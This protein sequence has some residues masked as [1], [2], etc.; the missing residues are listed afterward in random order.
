MSNESLQR[1]LTK[2]AK[3]IESD[4]NL[5]FKTAEQSR[6]KGDARAHDHFVHEGRIYR[7]VHGMLTELMRDHGFK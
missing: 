5:A 7:D 3:Q 2:L 1:D 6:E 4:A